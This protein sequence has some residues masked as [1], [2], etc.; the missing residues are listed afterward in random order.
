MLPRVLFKSGTCFLDN[1]MG[2]ILARFVSFSLTFAILIFLFLFSDG[3]PPSL[4]GA[5]H[6]Y[7][8]LIGVLTFSFAERSFF[9]PHVFVLAGAIPGGS[10]F[11]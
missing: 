9:P 10:F 3:V 4:F 8:R 2:F 5:L 6:P 11:F 7:S 1:A